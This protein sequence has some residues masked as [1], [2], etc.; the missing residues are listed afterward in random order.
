MARYLT[1]AAERRLSRSLRSNERRPVNKLPRQRRPFRSLPGGGGSCSEVDCLNVFG[2][3]T[4]GSV[5]LTYVINSETDDIEI[6]FDDDAATVQAAYEA[7]PGIG[8]D[9]VKVVGGPWP[10]VALHVI[11][12]SDLAGKTIEFPTVD[13][14]IT[15]GGSFRMWKASSAN[16]KGYA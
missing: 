4:G 6:A 14:N 7:H 10:E 12:S 13:D 5:T 1:N 8:A 15:G 11:F 2:V 9:N 16:W 3:V